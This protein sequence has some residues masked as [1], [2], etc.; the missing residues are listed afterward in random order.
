[1]ASSPANPGGATERLHYCSEHNTPCE[2][3]PSC[4]TYSYCP[5][6][7]KCFEPKCPDS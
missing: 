3:C 5:D 1:M 7:E 6:C 2:Q 4:E